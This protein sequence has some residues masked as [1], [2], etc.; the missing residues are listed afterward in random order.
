MLFSNTIHN[1]WKSLILFRLIKKKTRFLKEHWRRKFEMVLQILQ[2]NSLKK[3]FNQYFELF[4]WCGS[5]LVLAF[6]DPAGEHYSLCF[7]KFAGVPF[8]PGCGLGHSISYIFHGD[9]RSSFHSHPLGIFAISVIVLRIYKL[10]SLYIFNK[11]K[12]N[13]YAL[14]QRIQFYQPGYT[15]AFV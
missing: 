3:Y 6:C 4:F 10:T 2:A 7:F 13:D 5:L 12:N 15:K 14:W 11:N 8:C 1:L 9:F